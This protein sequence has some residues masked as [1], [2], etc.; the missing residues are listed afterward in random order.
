[1]SLEHALLV[2]SHGRPITQHHRTFSTEWDEIRD[3]S[4]KVY[5][6]YQVSPIGRH[7]HPRS[8][9]H[10]SNIGAITLTRFAYGVPV[11]IRD[12]SMDAG[13]AILLTTIGGHARHWGRGTQREETRSGESFMVDCSRVDYRVDFDPDHLQLNLTVPHELLERMALQWF[14]FVPDDRFWQYKCRMG[15]LGSSWLSLLE[16][17]ARSIAE[18]PGAVATGRIGAHLEQNLC[19]H[20]LQEW[21]A[22]AAQDGIDLQDPR[23]A[24]APRHVRAAEAFMRDNAAMLPT[25]TEIAEHV[26]VSVRTLTSAFRRFRGQSPGDFLREQRLQGVHRQLLAAEPG[27]GVSV[28]S[29]AFQWGYLSLGE[30]ARLYRQRFNELPSETLRRRIG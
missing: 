28:S 16:Y 17:T 18:A 24:L 21:A 7:I 3:W 8:T 23:H 5:M 25:L 22:R 13:N 9:M 6:P 12:W 26:G 30:F 27:S 10:S 1:M 15:G 29:V 11:T 4:D 2:D 14:G 19:I 20:L